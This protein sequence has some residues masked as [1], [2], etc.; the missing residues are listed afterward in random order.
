[1]PTIY[2]NSSECLQDDEGRACL[3]PLVFAESDRIQ[4]WQLRRNREEENQ[5]MKDVAGWKTGTWFGE[6][7]YKTNPSMDK[8]TTPTIFELYPH[9]RKRDAIEPMMEDNKYA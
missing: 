2:F 3:E 1:M 5:L 4:L 8:W 6:A 9:C 7:I